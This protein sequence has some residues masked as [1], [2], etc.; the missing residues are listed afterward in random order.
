MIVILCTV[1]EDQY[2]DSIVK[3]LVHFAL[4][5]NLN[6]Q[7]YS[8]AAFHPETQ[9]MEL[10]Q[11]DYSKKV[12]R[13]KILKDHSI[14]YNCVY[15][16]IATM[17]ENDWLMVNSLS[18]LSS[19]AIEAKELYF[20]AVEKPIRLSFYDASYLD[21]DVLQL[22]STSE[23]AQKHLVARIIDNYF[24]QTSVKSMSVEEQTQLSFIKRAKKN[25]LLDRLRSEAMC[26]AIKVKHESALMKALTA[27]DLISERTYK[28]YYKVT[29][30]SVIFEHLPSSCSKIDDFIPQ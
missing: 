27:T 10:I 23:P 17:G 19:T 16:L 6:K 7:S 14:R 15:S 28:H 5:A 4:R 30:R 18:D 8:Y 21:S 22:N 24:Y 26:V 13:P 1:S 3:P 25:Q 11:T 12:L 9:Q 20:K 29:N 2:N